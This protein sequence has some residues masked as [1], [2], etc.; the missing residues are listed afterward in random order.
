MHRLRETEGVMVQQKKE[1]GEVLTGLETKNRYEL[2]NE[3]FQPLYTAREEGGNFL[4]RWFLKAL[5]PFLI[6]IQDLGGQLVCKVERPF[7]FYFHHARVLDP[8]NHLLGGI[9]KKFSVL[10]RI[11]SVQDPSGKEKYR[12]KGPLWKPWTFIIEKE[13]EE[14]GR[15]VKKWSGVLK[16]GFT[17]ADNF[18]V[19][20][21][22]RTSPETR[23]L[24]LGAVFLIDFV[25]FENK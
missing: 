12:L 18:G 1:M 22:E 11:Y 2:T 6:L 23:A 9:T 24:L 19:T 20:F 14:K 16:E 4:L 15:I 21:P 17:D 25:H 7:R 3:A 13:G 8:K 5:R 10:S